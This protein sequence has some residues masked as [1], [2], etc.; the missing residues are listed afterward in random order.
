MNLA[1]VTK[2]YEAITPTSK[3]M[4]AEACKVMPGGVTANIKFFDPYP[5][6]MKHGNGAWLTDVDNNQY[7]DY[8]ASY[9]PL[10]LGHGHPAV[11]EAIANQL[12][13]HGS[14]L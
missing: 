6:F 9:G 12:E 4:Y 8:L 13:E 3:K 7:V 5:I 14:V 1:E 11:K 10:I 2:E